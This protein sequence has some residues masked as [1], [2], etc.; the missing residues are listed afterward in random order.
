MSDGEEPTHD[1]NVFV[2]VK[3]LRDLISILFLL[4]YY[5][6]ERIEYCRTKFHNYHKNNND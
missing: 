3:R 4:H 5:N 2:W 1:N 6:T